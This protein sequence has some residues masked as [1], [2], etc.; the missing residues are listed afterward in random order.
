MSGAFVMR[1]CVAA[2]LVAPTVVT[3]AGDSRPSHVRT[4]NQRIQ[5]VIRYALARSE[6]FGDLV[7]TLDQLD[8]VV[9]VEEGSCAD[10]EHRACIYLIPASHNLVV[11][12]D[13]RQSI[14]TAAAALAHELY[15]A[16]EVGRAPEVTDP[17][18]LRALYERIGERSCYPPSPHDCWETRAAQAFEELVVRQLADGKAKPHIKRRE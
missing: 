10:S 16:S 7:A 8:R 2:L 13:P 17:A 5:E 18:G 11:H 14:R 9:Y 3:A 4:D 12:F 6:S 15:H 1:A